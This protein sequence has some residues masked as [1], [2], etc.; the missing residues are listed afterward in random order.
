MKWNYREKAEIRGG[1]EG[2]SKRCANSIGA[3]SAGAAM[4]AAGAETK[5][6][7]GSTKITA[8]VRE[9]G[10]AWEQDIAQSVSPPVPW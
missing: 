3:N 1:G 5:A 4:V 7:S 9:E 8:D 10:L 6:G 2:G